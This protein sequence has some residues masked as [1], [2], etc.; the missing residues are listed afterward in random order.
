MPD[1]NPNIFASPAVPYANPASAKAVVVGQSHEPV[2]ER[3]RRYDDSRL[4]APREYFGSHEGYGL[5]YASCQESGKS[6][7]L[8]ASRRPQVHAVGF[9]MNYDDGTFLPRF[10]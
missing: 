7:G 2:E 8:I 1:E 4:Q 6:R 10:Y 5:T 3:S 9:L